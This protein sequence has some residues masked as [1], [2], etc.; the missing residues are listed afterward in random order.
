MAKKLTNQEKFERNLRSA[1]MIRACINGLIADGIAEDEDVID[2]FS[3]I[4][5]EWIFRNPVRHTGYISLE[6]LKLKKTPTN[7]HYFGR[8]SSGMLVYMYALRGA[9]IKRLA[10]IIASRSRCHKVTSEENTELKKHDS[11]N[12]LKTKPMVVSEYVNAN[13]QLTKEKIP[14]YIIN[15]IEYNTQTEAAKVHNCSV[16]TVVNRCVTD[17][18]GK[19]PNWKCEIR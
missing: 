2:E 5:A 9:S 10:Y 4:I 18:R 11:K 17:K 19:F 12:L 6:A 8:K 16:Q 3:G 14:V 15:E 1:R 7:D 13:I